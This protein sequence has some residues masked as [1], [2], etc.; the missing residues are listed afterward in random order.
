MRNFNL[1]LYPS[2]GKWGVLVDAR[3]FPVICPKCNSYQPDLYQHK[4]SRY[5]YVG[6][7]GCSCGEQLHLSDSDQEFVGHINI[8]STKKTLTI[9]FKEFYQ[10]T[11]KHFERLKKDYN[12][13]I[14][15]EHLN[16]KLSLE[17]MLLEVEIINNIEIEP[18]EIDMPLRP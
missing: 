9:E 10:L 14:Y 4:S 15:K 8:K 2:D 17:D 13:D 18:I 7:V 5:G 12:Y 16:T 3:I 6:A 11:E 1:V